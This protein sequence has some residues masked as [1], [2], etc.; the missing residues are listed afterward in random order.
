[1]AN[2][3]GTKLAIVAEVSP[4]ALAQEQLEAY[5][6]RDIDAFL[7]PYAKGVKVYS[8]PNKLE[9]EG[10]EEMR[11]RY[12]PKFETT[13]DLHCKIISRIVKGNVVIDEEEVTANGA[14]F[15]AVAIYEIVNGKI[16]VVRF[17]K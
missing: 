1:M 4:R 13:K 8:Y 3:E 10:I 16:A 7:K 6:K 14:T 15:H 17:V 2:P 5:N 11:K 9:Y 12:A